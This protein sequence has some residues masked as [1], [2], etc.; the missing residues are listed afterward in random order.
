MNGKNYK[1]LMK[2]YIFKPYIKNFPELFQRERERIVSKLNVP[3]VIEHIGS[4]AVP[5]L[6]GKGIIDIGI[7]SD[8]KDMEL[9]SKKLQAI[10][11]EFRP[12]FSTADRF[13]FIAYLSD[14]EESTRRYHIHLTYPENPEW[15]EFLD[16]RDYLIAHP[17]ALQ[18]YAELK[19]HAV[20]EAKDE[21]EKYRKIKDPLFKKI[22]AKIHAIN[23]PINLLIREA[24]VE[25]AREIMEAER[26]I[27]EEPG[28]FC[29]EPSE[30]TLENVINTITAFKDG[31]GLYLAAES[32]GKL[33]GH[34]FL[35]PQHLQ[36]LRHVVDL[37]IAVHLGW[38]NKG[39][40]TRLLKQIIEWAK[41]SKTLRKIQLNVRASNSTA[42]SLYKKMGFEE[43]GR[44][45]NRVKVKDDYVD[46]IIMGLNLVKDQK[47][48]DTL[49]RVMEKNDIEVLVNDFCFPWSSIQA[50]AEK[51]TRYWSENQ[52]GTRTVY[53]LEN[54]KQIIGY[55]SLLYVSEYLNFKSTGIP[56]INDVWITEKWR[57]KG[58]GKMLIRYIEGSARK[59]GFEQ[60]GIGVGLYADYGPAQKLYFHLRYSPDGCGIT[61]KYQTTI[62]GESYPLDDEL[63]LWLKKGL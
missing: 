37:N 34:A 32:D 16:F 7:A 11:Y 27:A 44:L 13:Y 54:E 52:E 38:Q 40:G 30:L 50:T 19:Q 55:A 8:K 2:K 5:G 60:I 26:A 45:R 33:V 29:S 22:R 53:L 3:L 39:I 47:S 12:H 31:N 51:W 42:I 63:I 4:T 41:E 6:G 15:K 61:Y 9:V 58:F 17:E 24:K 10:G 14:P 35:E 23:N 20:F 1:R 46:D 43:E 21:G 25:D 48:Q 59:M 28:Y 62:P 36:S 56:E 18:E 57:N 49:I